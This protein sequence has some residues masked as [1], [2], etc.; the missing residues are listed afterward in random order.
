MPVIGDVGSAWPASPLL[1]VGEIVAHER[2]G[3]RRPAQIAT[4]VDVR[5]QMAIDD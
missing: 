3:E 1:I 4:E 2:Q 5:C